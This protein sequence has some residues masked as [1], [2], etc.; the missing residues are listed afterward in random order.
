MVNTP[1]EKSAILTKVCKSC[2]I[3]VLDEEFPADLVVLLMGELDII[4]GLDWL[5]KFH[6]VLDCFEKTVTFSIPSQPIRKVQCE[7]Y[8]ESQPSVF[9]AHVK[10]ERSK[11]LIDKIFVVNF[12]KDFFQ[13]IT[14]LHPKREVKFS[15]DLIPEAWENL[16]SFLS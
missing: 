7:S 13:E 1:L 4:L 15:I 11:P 12:F 14:H 2:P 10:L 9:L 8:Q 3:N 5:T 6:A 16:G